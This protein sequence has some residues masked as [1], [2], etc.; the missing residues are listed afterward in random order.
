VPQEE[1]ASHVDNIVKKG[2][3]KYYDIQR[4]IITWKGDGTRKGYK[5]EEGFAIPADVA[6]VSLE[7][8][9]LSGISASANPNTLYFLGESETA[10][11]GLEGKNI[12]MGA[13]A[14]SVVLLD[15]YDFYTP[16]SFNAA[17]ISYSRQFTQGHSTNANGW[18]TLCLP[19][20]ATSV[21][22][23]TD[24]KAID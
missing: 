20:A 9:N 3:S 23:T 21:K 14:E 5:P 15:G 12:V 11:A 2:E 13:Q 16:F 6:A 1:D 10:P 22:N 7:G 18:S 19:F 24:N 17:N 4:G 8:L